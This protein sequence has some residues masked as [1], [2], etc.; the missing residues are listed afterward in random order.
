LKKYLGIILVLV[1]MASL[2]VSAVVSADDHWTV[3]D[4][5]KVWVDKDSA[6]FKALG[7]AA[8]QIALVVGYGNPYQYG[9]DGKNLDTAHWLPYAGQV[10]MYNSWWSYR[11]AET[12]GNQKAGVPVYFRD[13]ADWYI[14]PV[15]K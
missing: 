4:F 3:T 14:A 13:G 1:V 11:A 10:T 12:M 2:T 15:G 9:P 7:P 6:G 5:G 8:Q